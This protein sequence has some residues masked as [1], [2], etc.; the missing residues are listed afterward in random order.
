MSLSIDQA[1]YYTPAYIGRIQAQEAETAATGKDGDNEAET[2]SAGPLT[3]SGTP[4]LS[5]DDVR[6]L[7]LRDVKGADLEGYKG[8]LEQFYSDPANSDDPVAFLKNLSDEGIE[9]LKRAQS[10]PAGAQIDVD[11]LNREEAL[12]FILPH[13]RKVDLDNDGLVEGANGGKGFM[14]PPVNASQA[15]KDAWADATK[16]MSESDKMLLTGRFFFMAFSANLHVDENGKVTRTEPDEPGWRNVFAE[17]DFSYSEAIDR[18]KEGNEFNRPY[19][20]PEIYERIKGL[21]AK[22]EQAFDSHAIA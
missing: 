13:S 19:N 4:L 18:L 15:V 1:G 9:L 22:L 10:L 11:G 16:D 14:F 3:G 20:S 8:V 5:S 12:N 21:L 17:D 6:L 2:P 7:L